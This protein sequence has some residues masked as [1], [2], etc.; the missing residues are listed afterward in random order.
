MV[1][2][3]DALMATF[4]KSGTDQILVHAEACQHL[5]RTVSNVKEQGNQAGVAINPGTPVAAVEEVLSM[6]DIVMVM[7]VNPGFAGQSFIPESVD[8]IRR[9]RKVIDDARIWQLRSGGGRWRSRPTMDGTGIGEGRGDNPGC[10]QRDFQ[11]QGDRSRRQ[12]RGCGGAWPGC[13]SG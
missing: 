4:L 8:K 5:H 12:C 2:E 3:P 7:S 13:P 9:L 11:Q 1:R 6:L 10:G